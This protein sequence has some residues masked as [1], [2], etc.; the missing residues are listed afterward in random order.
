MIVAVV[1]AVICFV[2][3]SFLHVSPPE[4]VEL[5]EDDD[6]KQ[7]EKKVASTFDGI[8][9]ANKLI[10][11]FATELNMNIMDVTK[12]KSPFTKFS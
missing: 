9:L 5:F 4:A 1:A 11:G 12:E 8:R 3:G 6:G 2:L 10:P 7:V